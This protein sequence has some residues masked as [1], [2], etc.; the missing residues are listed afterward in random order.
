MMF[1]NLKEFERKFFYP[2]NLLVEKK[3]KCFCGSSVKIVSDR[4]G[5]LSIGPPLKLVKN[6][7]YFS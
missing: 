7:P 6:L 4:S 2:G 1:Q 3:L 5:V